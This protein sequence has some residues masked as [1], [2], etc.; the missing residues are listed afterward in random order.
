[1][2]RLQFELKGGLAEEELQEIHEQVLK[3]LQGIGLEVKHE[4]SRLAAARHPG[5]REDG[6]RLYF[7]PDLVE[8]FVRRAR[9]E[10]RA[11]PLSD[12]VK[13]T[14]PWNCFN[15][16]DLETGEIRPS[17]LEDV[18]QM[19]KLLHAAD[20]GEI[21]PVYPTDVPPRLQVLALEKASL[22]LTNSRGS[23]LEF[24]DYDMLEF[25]I[26]MHAA[27]G[28]RYHL[29]VQFPI[30]PLRT[31]PSA[32]ETIWRYKDR[33][34]VE[35]AASAGPIPQAGATAPLFMP[36][37]LV[38]AAAE[39][40]GSYILIR[41]VSE[42]PLHCLPGY[43]LDVFDLKTTV[44]V[45]SSP[46]HILYQLCLKDLYKFY[47]GAPKTSHFLQ[48]LAKRCDAQAM[49][50]RTAWMLTLALAG[51]REFWLGAGQLSMDEVFSPVMFVV[52]YEIA[53]FVT[54][55]I[56]GLD[57][58]DRPDV[59]YE[60]IAQGVAEGNYFLHESTLANMRQDFDS[61][62]F[63][64]LRLESWRAAGCPSWHEKAKEKARALIASHDFALPP[65]VQK[66]VDAVYEE[67]V[68]FAGASGR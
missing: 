55:I 60:A 63:P 27:A 29:S 50:E 41:L 57:Y 35:L 12:E 21:S 19:F 24:S 39:A 52:D 45:Y 59:S 3:V 9:E 32:L 37:A 5:V 26:A 31:N 10:H 44:T 4:E 6:N 22:E 33:D 28:R 1:M 68:A 40:I 38:Q 30:S 56:R 65:D 25:A 49:L 67:A 54:H 18:R 11:E 13:V 51:H 15:I 47:Y 20:A 8:E 16:E 43:R 14:G 7:A 23:C 53:R 17:T 2:K 42:K 64:R 61:D 46:V 36:G 48:S 62:V 66:D 34:D 58:D